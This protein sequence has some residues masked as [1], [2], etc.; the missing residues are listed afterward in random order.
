MK[1]VEEKPAPEASTP[2]APDEE[3]VRGVPET[4]G[5]GRRERAAGLR[6]EGW[7]NKQIAAELGVHPSTV[8]RWL[9]SPTTRSSEPDT[10]PSIKEES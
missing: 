8:G 1:H 5:V 3:T 9:T 4:A 2:T 10:S 7:S 6:S